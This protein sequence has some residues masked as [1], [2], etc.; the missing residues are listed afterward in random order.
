MAKNLPG[1]EGKGAFSSG[2]AKPM[3]DADRTAKGSDHPLKKDRS[4]M[5]TFKKGG[6]VKKGK[7]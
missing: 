2:R 7:K 3:T 1:K 5:P 6:K 4:R